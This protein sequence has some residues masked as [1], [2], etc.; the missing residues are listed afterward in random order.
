MYLSGSRLQR[1]LLQYVFNFRF[2]NFSV[3]ILRFSVSVTCVVVKWPRLSP[4]AALVSV[5]RV[6][7]KSPVRLLRVNVGVLLHVVEG[8]LPFSVCACF[9]REAL[10][11]ICF[12]ISVTCSSSLRCMSLLRLV[13]TGPAVS[14]SVLL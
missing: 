13:V 3:R 6:L 12:S 4:F 11:V 9:N 10:S 8:G 7:V 14:V 5:V 2:F 1:Q